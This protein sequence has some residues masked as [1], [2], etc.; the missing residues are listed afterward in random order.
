[1]ANWKER[2]RDLQVALDLLVDK[3]NVLP[4]RLVVPEKSE[5]ERDLE[6]RIEARL[7]EIGVPS[8][9][10]DELARVLGT[11]YTRQLTERDDVMER[12]SNLPKEAIA[13]FFGAKWMIHFLRCIGVEE[14][15]H[16]LRELTEDVIRRHG[17][18]DLF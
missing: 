17:L 18:D 15:P 7:L 12:V 16:S 3:F 1:M 6:D 8:H 10:H 14:T 11:H 5:A 2:H 4:S 13:T 9:V